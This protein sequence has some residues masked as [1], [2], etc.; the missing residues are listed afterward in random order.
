MLSTF[1]SAVS[2]VNLGPRLGG[3]R[4]YEAEHYLQGVFAVSVQ[5]AVY[6]GSRGKR[7]SHKL[8]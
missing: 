8:R 2:T 3:G 5:L 7:A 6:R 4:G 1:D